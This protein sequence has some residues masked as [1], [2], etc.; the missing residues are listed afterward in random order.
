VIRHAVARIAASEGELAREGRHLSGHS[1]PASVQNGPPT[2]DREGEYPMRYIVANLDKQ[3]YLK[4][5]DLGV[6][7]GSTYWLLLSTPD[8]DR[9]EWL[10]RV[11]QLLELE[12]G[13]SFG[14]QG[15]QVF[16]VPPWD[17]D[18]LVWLR[19]DDHSDTY[20]PE[21]VRALVALGTPPMSSYQ[22]VRDHFKDIADDLKTWRPRGVACSAYPVRPRDYSWMTLVDVGL[23]ISR[24]RSR[25]Q[26]FL[27]AYLEWLDEQPGVPLGVRMHICYERAIQ[28]PATR[29]GG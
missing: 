22:Y 17:H 4:T 20:V 16:P 23:S 26:A 9:K 3:Q 21:D 7:P 6:Y 5:P 13:R 14:P 2:Q 19:E 8:W 29:A 12:A 24:A 11:V 10:T 15:G 18:R 25:G 27:L 28:P 1:G